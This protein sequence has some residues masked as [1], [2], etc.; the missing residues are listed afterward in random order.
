MKY[1]FN[2]IYLVP[3]F[4]YIMT[5]I[6]K[7]VHMFQ[8]NSYINKRYF[9]WM[10]RNL[11]SC[12]PLIDLVVIAIFNYYAFQHI[13]KYGQLDVYFAVTFTFL[14]FK[15]VVLAS[16]KNSKKKLVYTN[17]VKRQLF[18][19][20]VLVGVTIN[21]IVNLDTDIELYFSPVNLYSK[22]SLF[23]IFV[24][25]YIVIINFVNLPYEKLNNYRYL[26]QAK[27]IL[28]TRKQL[29][30]VGITGSYGKTSSKNILKEVLSNHYYIHASPKSYNTP[31]GLTITIRNHLKP[32][33]QMFIAEMG[34]YKRGE[35][36]EL[37]RLVKPK[38]GILTSIGP[39]HLESFK[40]IENIVLGK[41]EL[42]ESLPKDGY[43][44]LN[45]DNEH[46]KNYKVKND[47]N[48]ITYSST[49]EDTDLF[50][51]DV[52]VSKDGTSF[53]V[54]TKCDGKSYQFETKLLGLH[55]VHNIL[56]ALGVAHSL[57]ID[58]NTLKRSIRRIKPIPHRLEIKD[59]G[60]YTLIDDAFNSNPIGSKMALDILEKMEGQKIII[61]PGM[62]E[63]GHQ[64]YNLNMKFGQYIAEVCDEVILV[65]KNQTKPIQDGLSSK[66][67]NNYHIVSNINEAFKVASR[68]KK[69]NAY[70]LIENDLPD[71]YDE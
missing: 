23:S 15:N 24:S 56:S 6:F 48:I 28:H 38:Y 50:L 46:I 44:I 35:I 21:H 66:G 31:M 34:A 20:T 40:S 14:S 1:N 17:R 69:D 55:N 61:T 2:Y 25:L 54:G 59:M 27:W 45:Y 71:L 51:F 65:G 37:A 3:L 29:L 53:K 63:L 5:S 13:Y 30:K 12:Y 64:Q 52:N 49:D 36:K 42:I 19:A 62:I 39:A 10:K 43:G 26:L 57:G 70:V 8:Q 18:T 4:F 60:S 7:Y 9:R 33:H 67:Y 58:F 32:L 22:L 16:F 11:R 41:F 47:C 68:L